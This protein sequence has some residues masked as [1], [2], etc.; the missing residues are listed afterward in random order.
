MSHLILS[1]FYLFFRRLVIIGFTLGQKLSHKPTDLE[2]VVLFGDKALIALSPLKKIL[3]TFPVPSHLSTSIYDLEFKSPLLLSSF[4]DDQAVIDLWL[5]F[6]LGGA[7]FKT[8]Y[9]E[10]RKGNPRPRIQ[11]LSLPEG[12]CLI[13]AMGIPG[14][15]V[16]ALI[17]T[18]LQTEH[19][20]THSPIGISIGGSTVQEYALCIQRI[21]EALAGSPLRRFYELNISCPNITKSKEEDISQ[22]PHLLD[23]LLTQIR[24]H[25]QAIIG[26]KLSPDKPND[27]LKLYAEITSSVPRTYL[28]LG[29]TTYRKC[30]Q[31]GLP[32]QALSIG[33]G[34]LSGFPL[35]ERTL[36][37]V[38]LLAP[39]KIPIIATG[40]I[41]TA[42]QVKAL[43]K[44]GATLIG[45]AT[46]VVQNP[47]C[48]PKILSEL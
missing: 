34:G 13:N 9:L 7:I 17:Q 35:F 4:K 29:N 43:Q 48:I 14:K 33:G 47:Y 18:L 16:H 39:Y 15:G 42:K 41:S 45:M 6:G 38:K 20:A 3:F 31:V 10:P 19:P 40:G 37:M 32:N 26:V 30:A 25:T 2:D 8:I 11:E 21:E 28:N 46:A 24:A 36:E 5:N 23:A 44:E 22:N 27:Y 1:G 12:R